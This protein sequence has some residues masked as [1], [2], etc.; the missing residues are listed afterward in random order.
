MRRT[1]VMAA[2][3]ALL[4]TSGPVGTAAP[5]QDEA[6]SPTARASKV[7]ALRL[8][9]HLDVRREKNRNYDRSKFADWYDADGDGCD[10]REEVLIAESVTRIRVGPSCSL[11]GGK[12]F[13][14]YDGQTTR[15][16]S[17]FDIDHLVPLAEAWGSG[18]RKWGNTK[19]GRFSN[20]LGYR[21]SLIAVSASSNRS[22]G[23]RDPSEWLPPRR[24]YR[25]TYAKTYTA[26]KWRWDLSVNPSERN[27]LRRLISNCNSPKILKPH[28]AR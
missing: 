17:T 18:A 19:R 14:K 4:L 5:N 27:A 2:V 9:R 7:S 22:K 6:S 3:V 26:T 20:D 13:S 28:R 11:R 1:L 15:N 8:L 21:Y 24:S 12:W 23:D 16:S 25:C 10:T